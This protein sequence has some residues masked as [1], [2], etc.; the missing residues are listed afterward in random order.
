MRRLFVL[1]CALLASGCFRWAPVSSL[2]AID[3][4]RIQ[5]EES[6]GPR[7]LFHATASGRIIEAETIYGNPVAVDATASRVFVRRL[8][9]PATVAIVS[10]SGL[11]LAGTIAAV[12][13]L[14]DNYVARP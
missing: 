12:Q 14:I 8:N 6:T 11:A 3:D 1:A 4:D 2:S 9:V 5:V 7:T 10:A 13:R